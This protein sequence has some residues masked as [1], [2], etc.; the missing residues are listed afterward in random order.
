MATTG[1]PTRG[2]PS[3]GDRGQKRT[4]A[5]MARETIERSDRGADPA[6]GVGGLGPLT[7]R[8][9]ARLPGPRIGWMAIW[10]LLPWV[11][12]ATF[13]WLQTAG[14]LA[15][16]HNP[17]GGAFA[18]VAFSSAIFLSLWGSGKIGREIQALRPN[19][20]RMVRRG[21]EDPAA[22]F[23][24]VASTAGPLLLNAA[25]IV[26]FVTQTVLEAGW[27]ESIV[28]AGAWLLIGPAIWTFVWVYLSLQVGLDRLGRWHL[29]LD[30]DSE[31]RYLGLR[32]VG[33][34]AFSAFWILVA[35]AAPL[36]LLNVGD[37]VTLTLTL[38]VLGLGVGVFFLSLRRLNR[39]MVASKQQQ[40][41]WARGLYQQALRPVKS[42]GTLEAV[43]R[44]AALL[45]V[46]EA[47]ERRAER[48][49]EWPF[50]EATFA[51]VVAIASFVTAGTLARL[52]LAPFGI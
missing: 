32:P 38:L 36:A 9:L 22:L 48:I 13:L 23:R 26:V 37:L 47:L 42:Q 7:E 17:A 45:S 4:Y 44:Q 35:A 3:F 6:N 24:N 12:H 43:E 21:S 11:E 49:Q 10:A 1:A 52:I 18:R 39:R 33:R 16:R 5:G 27:A 14:I 40:L 19:L 25:A 28:R 2:G 46:T 34:L 41:A 29:E 15:G 30:P 50:D 51:R 20:S 31:D 8:I